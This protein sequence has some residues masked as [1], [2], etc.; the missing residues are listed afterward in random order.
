MGIEGGQKGCPTNGTRI[1]KN[2]NS[3]LV[4]VY[5]ICTDMIINKFKH[6]NIPHETLSM[7]FTENVTVFSTVA[8]QGI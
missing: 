5:L 1:K 2:E 4:Q 7:L 6:G 3:Y 8:W